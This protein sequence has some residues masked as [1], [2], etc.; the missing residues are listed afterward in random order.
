MRSSW[1]LLL[2]IGVLALAAPVLA[3]P[4]PTAEDLAN[5]R[6]TLERLRADREHYARLKEDL[7][8]F[9][10][11]R[12]EQQ[13]AM[14]QLDQ[15]LHQEDPAVQARL[16]RVL[17]R[18]ATWVEKLSDAD[19]QRLAAAPPEQRLQLIKEL[20]EREWVDRLPK[21]K[22]EQVV[23]TPLGKR[24]EVIAELRQKERERRLEWLKVAGFGDDVPRRIPV[25][26]LDLPPEVQ[27][28]VLF[29]L[30]PQLNAEEKVKLKKAEGQTPLY[31]RTLLELV[32]KYPGT[33]PGPPTGPTQQKDLPKDV[34]QKLQT[35][36]PKDRPRLRN[37][38]GPWPDYA[39]AVTEAIRRNGTMP[40]ELGPCKP[41]DFSEAVQQ[42]IEKQL[43]PQLDEQEKEKL[44]KAEGRWP[45]YPRAVRDL[46]R[47]HG[48]TV[49]ELPPP[50]PREYWDKLRAAVAEPP[51]P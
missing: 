17:D 50:G 6:R 11:L 29:L 9:Q 38:E 27:G 4:E 8:E 12:P 48:L 34:R 26:I 40:T 16:W 46:A 13:A 23:N 1:R 36:P 3:L 37:N 33:L 28:F 15:A 24:G 43:L 32:D 2:L 20:R 18:Y 35:L 42:F 30:M 5:N 19:K 10:G 31:A 14:R 39:I 25:R 49:P 44:A 7:K 22:R 41:K 45:D 21:A 47:A 51:R